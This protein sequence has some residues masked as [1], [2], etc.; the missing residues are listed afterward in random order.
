M[1]LFKILMY[2]VTSTIISEKSFQVSQAN[3]DKEIL[4]KS[5]MFPNTQEFS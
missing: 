2:I 3:N 4:I 5:F 1:I